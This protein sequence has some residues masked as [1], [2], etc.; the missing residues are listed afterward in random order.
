MQ[1][2]KGKEQENTAHQWQ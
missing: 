1:D 2:I